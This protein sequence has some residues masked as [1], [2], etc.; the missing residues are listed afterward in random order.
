MAMPTGACIEFL[1][2]D[3]M[4]SSSGTSAASRL[5]NER[6][7]ASAH[8]PPVG[9]LL[10]LSCG[11]PG[12]QDVGRGLLAVGASVVDVSGSDGIVSLPAGRGG[13]WERTCL[14]SFCTVSLGTASFPNATFPAK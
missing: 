11:P 9:F 14:R 13:S 1:R 6:L 3:L 4:V 8:K 12:A 10:T 5:R 7:F 2:L